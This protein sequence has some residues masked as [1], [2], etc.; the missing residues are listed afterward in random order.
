MMKR[1]C[2]LERVVAVLVLFAVIC[3]NVFAQDGSATDKKTIVVFA[4]ASTTNAVDEIKQAFNKQTG[5]EIQTSYAASALLAKQIVNGADA[6]IFISADTKWANYL[7]EK[8]FVAQSRNALGNRLVIVTPNDFK[9]DIKKP[10][11]LFDKSIEHIAIGEP[12]SVPAGEYAKAALVKLNLWDKLKDKFVPAQDV[13][14]A[15]MYV[16]TGAAEAGIVYATDAAISKKTKIAFAISE[17]LTGPIRYPIVLLVKGKE[18]PEAKKF[19]NYLFSPESIKI[20]KKY[21]FA[22]QTQ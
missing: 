2:L 7:A 13:R 10:G 17:E 18:K 3:A 11:D 9:Q 19:F 4:A 12:E 21:G 1:F 20:F 8:K 5:I 16:E 6:D 15:L 22:V 14:Q